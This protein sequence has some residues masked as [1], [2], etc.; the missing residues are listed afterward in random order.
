MYRKQTN[1]S[2]GKQDTDSRKRI[3]CRKRIISEKLSVRH[4]NKQN[5]EGYNR[6]VADNRLF[7]EKAVYMERNLG[8]KCHQDMQF[9]A[10]G[11]T[12]LNDRNTYQYAKLCQQ[13]E[14]VMP[15]HRSP[16]HGKTPAQ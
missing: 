6:I 1:D 4:R 13:G 5:Q 14:H 2:A 10:A 11:K 12:V 8:S 16:E 7:S 3:P 9:H 15:E